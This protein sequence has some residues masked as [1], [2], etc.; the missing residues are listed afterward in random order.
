M[1]MHAA[2]N[3]SDIGSIPISLNE[4]IVMLQDGIA[5]PIL[6]FPVHVQGGVKE[7]KK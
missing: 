1:V 7:G 6:F 3:S 5:V 4:C 2:H